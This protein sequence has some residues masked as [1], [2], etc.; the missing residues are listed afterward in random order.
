MCRVMLH[1]Q[2]A[3]AVLRNRLINF[4]AA[5]IVCVEIVVGPQVPYIYNTVWRSRR[6]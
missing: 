4:I 1:L 2:L 6:H 5:A 3:W